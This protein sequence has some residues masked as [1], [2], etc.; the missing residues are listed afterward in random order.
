MPATETPLPTFEDIVRAEGRVRPLAHHT[1]LIESHALSDRLGA[2]VYLK[3][4]VLQ[5]TGSFK[6]RGAANRLITLSAAQRAQGV[7]AASAGNHAQGVALAAARLGMPCTI[8]MPKEA[9]IAKVQATRA[10]GAEVVLEGE[11]FAQCV[12]RARGLAAERGLT[13]IPAFDDPDVIAG[14]GTLGLELLDDM[15]EVTTVVV[16]VGGG[17]LA[18]G[19]A[20]AVKERR[21]QVRV[22]GVQVEQARGAW[23]SWRT[24]ERASIR[25]GPTVADGIAV[26]APGEYTL[27][28]LRRYLDDFVLVDERSVAAAILFLL[29]SGKLVVEGAG[30]V[31]VAA[32]LSGRTAA[33]DRTAVILSGGNIDVHLLQHVV[34]HGLAYAGRFETFRLTVRD[35]P[36]QLAA[37][38]KTVADRGGNLLTVEH[39][40]TG[41][42]LPLNAVEI[43]LVV[44]TRDQAHAAEIG[45]GLREAGFEAVAGRVAAEA[46]E[47]AAGEQQAPEASYP[48]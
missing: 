16:P 12:E 43:E 7:V 44:E 26:R 9:S 41:A 11:D 22:V 13:F 33:R 28:L 24:G 14:Q 18:A 36:G 10:Y 39:K 6:I 30:A 37:I 25:P 2:Q 19:V 1:P 42:H 4:E 3:A 23:E 47:R 8:V 27:P 35:R 40:R 29:E 5:R 20:M 45:E 46:E 34:E 38:L 21:P 32:L 15:P 17:G 48:A 31:G